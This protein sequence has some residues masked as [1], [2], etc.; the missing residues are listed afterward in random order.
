MYVAGIVSPTAVQKL[1]DQ[2]SR[3]PVGI[4]PFMVKEWISKDQVVLVRNPAY[5]WAPALAEH[6]G[7]AYLDEIAWRFVLEAPTRTAVI[8]TGEVNVAEDL[9][10]ADVASLEKNADIRTCAGAR[11][12]PDDLPQRQRPPTSE[13]AVGPRLRHQQDAIVKIA[14]HGEPSR[15]VVLQPTTP[16]YAP[17]PRTSRP[18]IRPRPRRPRRDGWKPAPT[19][20][21]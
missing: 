10:Y 7:P 14:F 2:F 1:G 13:L 16:G 17:L 18:M 15:V 20:S 3:K 19:V 5:N 6:Q 9:S 11:A 21:V 12:R 4:G 8:Q